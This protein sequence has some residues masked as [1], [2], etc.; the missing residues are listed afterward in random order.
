MMKDDTEELEAG[1]CFRNNGTKEKPE[2]ERLSCSDSGAEY[3][4]IKVVDGF[5][6]LVCSDVKGTTG[7]LSQ[8]GLATG[9]E[10]FVICFRDNV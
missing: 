8:H 10:S 6:S 3:K 2:T 5:T 1:D 4:V 9:D 7:T